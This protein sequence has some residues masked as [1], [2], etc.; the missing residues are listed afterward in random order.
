MPLHY[1][2][3]EETMESKLSYDFFWQKQ[4]REKQHFDVC[5]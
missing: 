2:L 4:V 3:S 1:Y 5:T